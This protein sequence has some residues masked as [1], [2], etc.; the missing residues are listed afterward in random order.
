MAKINQI[1]PKQSFEVVRDQIATILKNELKNQSLLDTD[2]EE[3]EV[4]IN[5]N[6][7]I[8]QVHLPAVNVATERGAYENQSMHYQS[9]TYTFQIEFYHY[10]KATQN[11]EGSQ[12][13]GRK[14]EELMG[15]ARYILMDPAYYH[16]DLDKPTVGRRHVD[17]FTVGVPNDR[18]VKSVSVA[19]MNFSA[20]VSELGQLQEAQTLNEHHTFVLVNENGGYKWEIQT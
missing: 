5:R 11:E 17:D 15:R 14:L 19:A 1:I 16:L 6:V 13:S 4:Y 10:G 18:D 7:N 3:P 8:D 9:G 20:Q 12:I 2:F